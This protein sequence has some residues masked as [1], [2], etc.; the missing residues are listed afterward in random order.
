L[1]EL[2]SRPFQGWDRLFRT[3]QNLFAAEAA[4]REFACLID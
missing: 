4:L 2:R 1:P 3:D